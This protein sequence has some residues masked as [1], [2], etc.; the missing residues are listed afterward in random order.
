MQSR[1]Y[2]LGVALGQGRTLE[3]ILGTRRSVTEGVTTAHAVVGL[4]ARLNVDMPICA[5]IHRILSHDAAIDAVLAA[6]LDRP[7]KDENGR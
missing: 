2:S 1:N 5:A 6:L 4:A 7:F 3:E